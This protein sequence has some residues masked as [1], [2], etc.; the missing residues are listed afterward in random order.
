MNILKD[1]GIESAL[2]VVDS[3]KKQCIRVY[4]NASM[5]F[6]PLVGEND[7]P[8]LIEDGFYTVSNANGN[9]HGKVS[10]PNSVL[11]MDELIDIAHDVSN[12]YGLNLNF[13]DANLEYFKDESVCTINI[14]L[15]VSAFRTQNGFADG[16]KLDLFIKTGFGGVSCIEIGIFTYRFVCS[17]GLVM[18]NGLNYFKTKHTEKMN[19]LAKVFLSKHLPTMLDSV[20]EFTG[21]AKKLD[22]TEITDE[23]IEAFRQ[24]IFNY[25]KDD[26]LSTKKIN[27]IEA[28]NLGLTK[29]MNRTGATAWSLLQGATHYTNHNHYNA[30]KEFV[31]VGSGATFNEKAEKYVLAM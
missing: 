18:R 26:E 23:Q 30:S 4:E 20:N 14:P 8:K 1:L 11:Q 7:D 31:S 6:D 29:E 5:I 17:N 13:D 12:E 24:S 16:T 22:K 19:E 15:G 25:K 3:L 27:M 10:N 9:I 2:S 28:F 21:V